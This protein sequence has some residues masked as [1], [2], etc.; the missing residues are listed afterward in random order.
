MP[1]TKVVQHSNK[2]R[3]LPFCVDITMCLSYKL[4]AADVVVS[5][6]GTVYDVL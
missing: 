6:K 2:I 1:C 3:C 4:Q 5:P